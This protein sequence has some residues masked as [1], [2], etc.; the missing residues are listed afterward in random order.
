MEH[1]YKEK[2]ISFYE[3]KKRMPSYSEMAKLFGY[4]SKN[5]VSK[6]V[7]RMIEA[8]LV[9]KD[10]LGKLIPETALLGGVKML[11][12]VEAGFATPAEE[13]LLDTISLDDFLIKK[14]DASFMLKVKGDS[15]YDA[16]IRDG[17]MVIV[18]RT[19][20]PKVGEIVIAEIDGGWTM[21]YLRS[22]N[23]KMY[24]EPANKDFSNIYPEESLNIA[25]V[26]KAVIRKY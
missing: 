9:A 24:L 23:G 14:H 1:A 6:L 20:E 4:K 5:A 12:L 26:V 2:L 11:G 16:G 3:S 22:K 18:E 21:K 13:S 7:D 8:G 15:M 19:T 10:S 17:D 25:A